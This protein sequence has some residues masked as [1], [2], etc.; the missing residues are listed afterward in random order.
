[1]SWTAEIKNIVKQGG[2][3]HIT[4]E[5]SNGVET[6][7]KTFKLATTQNL[8][9]LVRSEISRISSLYEFAESVTNGNIDLTPEPEPVVVP[10]Q[11]NPEK[12]AFLDALNKFRDGQKLFDSG[13]ITSTQLTGLKTD[14]KALY[15]PQYQEFI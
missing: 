7:G 5:L 10:E 15:K 2:E 12:E 6:V 1:M 14:L 11:P 9:N 8:K 13:I 4:V 3:V